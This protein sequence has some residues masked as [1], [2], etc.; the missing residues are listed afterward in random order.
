MPRTDLFLF[1]SVYG[2]DAFRAK[3]GEPAALA[4]VV[5]NG[6]TRAEFEPIATKPDAA[7]LV[8]VGELRTLKGVDVLIDAIAL[9]AREGQRVSVT[10]VGDGPDRAAFETAG[11]RARCSATGY[12]SSAARRLALP[13]RSGG[14]SSCRRAR[15]RC[16]ISSSKR[17]RPACR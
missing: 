9:L 7:D 2:R 6:V 15:N 8:F 10:I 16:P 4:R 11:R 14:G 17:R 12:V 1:E 13:L 3:V 5:H